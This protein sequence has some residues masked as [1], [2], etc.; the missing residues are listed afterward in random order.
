MYSHAN[1]QIWG[2]LASKVDFSPCISL[3]TADFSQSIKII[4][5]S[6]RPRAQLLFFYSTHSFLL[7]HETHW[8]RVE[9]KAAVRGPGVNRDVLFIFFLFFFSYFFGARGHGVNEE[10]RCCCS[11]SHRFPPEAS[12]HAGFT[13][14]VA[15]TERWVA[16]V[17]RADG[18]KRLTH[19]QE[20]EVQLLF[21]CR[22]AFLI[23]RPNP[24]NA[25]NQTNME[26]SGRY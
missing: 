13:Q 9:K 18:G 7:P 2:L 22:C 12:Q 15:Q 6:S 24:I 20:S 19:R 23:P 25:P 14:A 16:S 1:H 8:N 5:Q 17:S 4:L 3:F 21:L 10:G 11:N 26:S